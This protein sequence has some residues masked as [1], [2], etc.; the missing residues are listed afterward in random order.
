MRITFPMLSLGP[1][2]GSRVIADLANGLKK[3]GHD[4]VFVVP[5]GADR[6]LYPLHV[7]IIA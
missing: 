2:G 5:K 3:K 1:S 6:D 4:V 7:N